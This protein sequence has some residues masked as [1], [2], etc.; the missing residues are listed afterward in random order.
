M[1]IKKMLLLFAVICLCICVCACGGSDS[2]EPDA[3]TDAPA[4]DVTEEQTAEPKTMS[5]GDWTVEVPADFELKGGDVFDENDTRYFSVKKSSFSYFDF[6]AEGE[7][8]IMS[9]YNYNKETYTN[10]QTDV[11]GSFGGNDWV[12]FQYGDG[13]GGYGFEAY[14]TVDGEM[15][16]VSSAG[17]AFDNEI[18]GEVLG[19]LKYT[20]VSAEAPETT[21]PAGETEP[22]EEE[23][24]EGAPVYVKI[25][26]L[27]D[28][29][30]G[31]PEGYTEKKD[32]TP[33]Q[34]VMDN[35][36]TGGRISIWNSSGAIEDEIASIMGSIDYELREET[37][38][39]MNWSIAVS[40][41][42][43]CFGTQLGDNVLVITIDYGG[44]DEE[45][46]SL[47]SAITPKGE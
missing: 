15:I 1:K 32:G 44:T 37:Y 27:K 42:Y 8:R 24:T 18:V 23:P 33:S 6:K 30:M 25:I 22:V 40:D 14:T 28:V 31:I 21:E 5:W 26:E 12:G 10:E 2:E 34:Y 45:M 35:D 9:N 19:S 7:D 20:P 16:R 4:A 43:Y 36:E 17:F 41:G 39:G 29:Y 11:S 3:Q 46:E 13:Y 47:I 38:V